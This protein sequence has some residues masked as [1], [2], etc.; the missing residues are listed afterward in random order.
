M[1]HTHAIETCTYFQVTKVKVCDKEHPRGNINLLFQSGLNN[2][3][4]K[5]DYHDYLHATKNI[6]LDTIYR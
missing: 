1:V 6:L 5:K 3:T 2:P 4:Q